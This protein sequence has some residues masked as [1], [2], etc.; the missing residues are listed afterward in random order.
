MCKLVL[1]TQAAWHWDS[2]CSAKEEGVHVQDGAA[3]QAQSCAQQPAAA[4]LTVRP[5]VRPL[6]L[7]PWQQSW[8]LLKE[9]TLGHRADKDGDLPYR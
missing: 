1:H 5:P 9:C 6:G 8:A 4:Q 7:W 3:C 2:S